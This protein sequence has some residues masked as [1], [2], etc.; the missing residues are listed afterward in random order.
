[1]LCATAV[2]ERSFDDP[3]LQTYCHAI[4]MSNVGTKKEVVDEEIKSR[5][6]RLM[7]SRTQNVDNVSLTR[8]TSLCNASMPPRPHCCQRNQ[9]G[10]NLDYASCR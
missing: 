9:V 2:K 10:S 4:S 7:I 8:D 3:E 5:N 1:M 6:L